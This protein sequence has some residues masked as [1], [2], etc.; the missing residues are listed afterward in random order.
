MSSPG[1]RISSFY[2]PLNTASQ[3]LHKCS[4]TCS[5]HWCFGLPT[6]TPLL[7]SEWHSWHRLP[8]PKLVFHFLSRPTGQ[9]GTICSLYI[10]IFQK[11]ILRISVWSHLSCFWTCISSTQNI[12]IFTIS[13]YCN[14]VYEDPVKML[15]PPWELSKI[16]WIRS[17]VFLLQ[18]FSPLFV[19][20]ASHFLLVFLLPVN[21]F[22]FSFV[23]LEN[24]YILFPSIPLFC[25]HLFGHSLL[26]FPAPAS[27]PTFC[28]V[29]KTVAENTV[30]PR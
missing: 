2:S 12:F 17:N 15:L 18:S 9:P 3:G 20:L 28:L 11:C 10:H 5:F 24:K 29:H 26:I 13:A 27:L 22:H 14:A 23:P 8:S 25:S 6:P 19:S 7:H 30:C 1:C 4:L 21:A 16:S